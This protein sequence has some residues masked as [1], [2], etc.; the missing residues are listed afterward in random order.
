[1]P[2]LVDVTNAVN[3]LSPLARG[4]LGWWL[5]VPPLDA[6]K[7]WYDL[8]NFHHVA[9][10][11]GAVFGDNAN[12][13]LFGSVDTPGTSSYG[14]AATASP[15]LILGNNGTVSMWIRPTDGA[16]A[17]HVPA[18]LYAS[19][20]GNGLFFNQFA[21]SIWLY[22]MSDSPSVQANDTLALNTWAH[23]CCANVAGALT[24]Y[25]NGVSRAT[26]TSGGAITLAPKLSIGA[27]Q[28]PSLFMQG[29]VDDIQIRDYG[30][31][32][33]EAAMLFADSR[34]RY[35][36]LLNRLPDAHVLSGG[37]FVG[38]DVSLN[39]LTSLIC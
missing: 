18:A 28:T 10:T 7:T 14:V 36:G 19:A 34:T 38:P 23:I 29:Q 24:M 27:T 39:P 8:A 21:L 2:V 35:T 9:M 15:R 1:M 33:A 3:P 5:T 6:G 30:M 4:L 11:G 20:V 31:N 12:H 26:G 13:G 17:S 32:A 22:W 37:Q 25:V 16:S